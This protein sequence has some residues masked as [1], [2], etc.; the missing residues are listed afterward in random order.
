MA[1]YDPP[2][3]SGQAKGYRWQAA[4][5]N[6]HGDPG[7]VLIAD[8]PN[9]VS[10]S[11]SNAVIAEAGAQSGSVIVSRT[12]TQGA[13]DINYQLSGSAVYGSDYTSAYAVTSGVASFADGA[14]TV[15]IDITPVNDPDVETNENVV[16]KLDVGT[17]YLFSSARSVS[18][19]IV[20]D[21]NSMPPEFNLSVIDGQATEG[22]DT[23]ML[24]LVRTG[25]SSGSVT[26]NVARTA[27]TAEVADYNNPDISS[28]VF[29]DAEMSVLLEIIPANDI[30]VEG[31][32]WLELSITPDLSYTV[33]PASNVT[34]NIEDDEAPHNV[35]I[36]VP[37]GTA[38]EEASDPAV[39]R[40]TRDGD[41]T[42]DLEVSYIV[43][44]GTT[45]TASDYN[46]VD[47]A[48]TVT[49]PGGSDHIDITLIP[50]DDAV[51]EVTE[52][53]NLKLLTNSSHY[54]VGG[55]S[56]ASV[57]IADNDQQAPEA[58]IDYYS[59]VRD[60][61]L[62]VP[63]PGVLENDT[64]VNGEALTAVL[65]TTTTNGTLSLSNNGSFIYTPDQGY[66]GTDSFTYRAYD[67]G[68][69][70]PAVTA[71]VQVTYPLDFKVHRGTA[72]IPTGSK[73]LTLANGEDYNLSG[74]ATTSSAFIR[75][76]NSHLTGGGSTNGSD[77][78]KSTQHEAW[79]DNP[80]NLITSVDVRRG[81]SDS[82][83][84][85]SWEIIEYVGVTGGA[86]EMIVR[87]Q[88]RLSTASEGVVTGPVVDS[89]S[90][91]N[92]VVVFITGHA[93]S[94]GKNQPYKAA[95]TAELT[96]S[97]APAFTRDATIKSGK[98]SYAVVEFTGSNW[99]DVQRVEHTIGTIASNEVESITAVDMSK[100][101]MHVQFRGSGNTRL[102]GQVW[103]SASDQLTFRQQT[104][105][106]G[107]SLAAWIVENK[108]SDPAAA[109]TVQHIKRSHPAGTSP[110]EWT[111]TITP[112][113][114]LNSSSIMGEVSV[115]A[116]LDLTLKRPDEVMIFRNKGGAETF[117][118][119]SVVEWPLGVPGSE[120]AVSGD[121]VEIKAGDDTP[122]LSDGTEYG[123]VIVGQPLEQVFVVTNNGALDLSLTGTPVVAISGAAD[124][125]V[126]NQPTASIVPA[127][128]SVFTVRFKP[129]TAGVKTA[130]VSIANNDN[131]ENPYTFAIQGTGLD[132]PVVNS[133]MATGIDG[134]SA[135]VHGTLSDGILADVYVYW[136][137]ING[138]TDPSQWSNTGLL[139]SVS[140]GVPFSYTFN[141]LD[142]GAKYYYNFCATNAAG[143]DWG[144][145][146][147]FTTLPVVRNFKIHR[148][149]AVIPIGSTT[150][151][152]VNGVDYTLSTNATTSSA[153]IRLVNSCL[154]GG[155]SS[156][157][158]GERSCE[159]EA[160]IDNPGNIL[161]SVNIERGAPQ[162]TS[163]NCAVS[164]EII[165]YVGAAGGANEMIVRD[166]VYM[167]IS[168]LDNTGAA[169]PGILDS[170]RVVVFVTGQGVVS[171]WDSFYR[172]ANT[173]RLN[174]S[175]EPVFRKADTTS[176]H[177]SYAVVEFTGSNWK[178][179][180]RVEH[181]MASI[182]TDEV[183]PITSVDTTK[184]F[185][186][187]Q[188]RGSAANQIGGQAW[189][190][191][192]DQL[193][194][195]Q[196][197]GD[198]GQSLVAWIVENKESDPAY[199][200]KVQNVKT[201]HP[202]GTS[203]EEWAETITRLRIV[204]SSSIMG[205]FSINPRMNFILTGADEVTIFRY[206]SWD[207]TFYTYS[208]VE[209]PWARAAVPADSDGDGLSDD[210]ELNIHF[211]DPNN[212]DS[213]GDGMPDG[214]EVDYSLSPTNSNDASIDSDGD[215]M[216]NLGEYYGGTA[217][218]DPDSVFKIIKHSGH[219]ANEFGS[220]VQALSSGADVKLMWLGGTNGSTNAYIIYRSTSLVD[221]VW[222]PVT[223]Y[224]RTNASGTNVWVDTEVSNDWLNIFY[225]IAAPTN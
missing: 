45:V 217:A 175:K 216:A 111:E 129:L 44:A 138:G 142:S 49:I 76:V 113:H 16:I 92:R 58:G 204:D 53:L 134:F 117:Y 148:G 172:A 188:C 154:T 220:L 78:V 8:E 212:P 69:Y 26:V 15:Q 173:A 28:V 186:H 112:V 145:S 213:D 2:G 107:Q 179:V 221:G 127:G 29:A 191:A 98:L 101:F 47:F 102:G 190:S 41:N 42:L 199:A 4:A 143:S 55:S 59:V 189:F 83:C 130:E 136:G 37:D 222:S 114:V 79:I 133:G 169:V 198:L 97:K 24:E 195:R 13:Q 6:H 167:E 131:D 12:L 205:E 63:E 60:D 94:I 200:M 40:V 110:E 211:T 201:S 156:N 14:A 210:D 219:D 176:I 7:L 66:L 64:D 115:S 67:G 223:N 73:T 52:F 160:W 193:T 157:G 197:T 21:N 62:T 99:K 68:L 153:F 184:A 74:D 95:Y 65:E 46:Y 84:A 34:V 122:E 126:T 158:A 181:T 71:I 33:G 17:N 139:S 155:G 192:S 51:S 170:D 225:K 194:F 187:V 119:Y 123:N 80:G 48:G 207:E 149:T 50:V 75:L 161:T 135:Q 57:S 82:S 19:T 106:L 132:A 151:T 215:G 203:P 56:A 177:L 22:G 88:A 1:A 93:A 108:E 61:F 171:G 77:A 38:D 178:D 31:A 25:N 163:Y 109:M 32:E 206:L 103:F 86:N 90:D 218:N 152:L 124:F 125:A 70:S 147:S 182:A 144:L 36:T 159:H 5:L 43:D 166:Q 11:V 174:T 89:I 116:R 180:Q 150:L 168:S 137:R 96:P 196:Q 30:L 128:S 104:G 10:I 54:V 224:P 208:V 100:A 87:A 35:T 18:V 81:N 183:E 118:T 140:Q 27:G 120:M 85:V 141:G 9:F 39:F 121:G 20:D 162:Y 146:G 209:W 202:A 72:V 185:M 91:T 3:V 164:W 23:A 165:E 214:W 105:D